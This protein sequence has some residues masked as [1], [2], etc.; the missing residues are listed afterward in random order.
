[1]KRHIGALA[2]TLCLAPVSADAYTLGAQGTMCGKFF[3][4]AYGCTGNSSY[5][6]ASDF[7][8]PVSVYMADSNVKLTKLLVFFHGHGGSPQ[9]NSDF[10]TFAA[11]EGYDVITIDYDYS[12]DYEEP[13]APRPSD[14]SCGGGTCGMSVDAVCGCYSDCYGQRNS[15]AWNGGSHAGLPSVSADWSVNTRL[16]KVVNWVVGHTGYAR[17]SNYLDANQR[18][19]MNWSRVTVAG[20]SLGSDLAGYIGKW[21]AVDRVIMMSGPASKLAPDSGDTVSWGKAFGCSNSSSSGCGPGTSFPGCTCSSTTYTYGVDNGIGTC[22]LSTSPIGWVAD[23][24]FGGNTGVTWQTGTSRIYGFEDAD[25]NVANWLA[26]STISTHR[27]WL[28]I[29]LDARHDSGFSDGWNQVGDFLSPQGPQAGN[30]HGVLS[31]TNAFF[32]QICAANGVKGHNAVISDAAC[33]GAPPNLP[34][35]NRY[36]VWD[37]ILTH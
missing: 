29:N 5:V 18:G 8:D 12:R 16:S 27:N 3:P 9:G 26:P 32:G 15:L 25:D 33:V 10:L 23:N 6:E 13:S 21:Q 19:G 1:M 4:T 35:A 31:G 20:H 2:I 7:D 17:F 11:E 14:A 36:E 22:A 30:W 24:H 34:A 28:S 37:F